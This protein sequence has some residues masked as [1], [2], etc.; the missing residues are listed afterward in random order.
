M[1]ISDIDDGR[2][3]SPASA[4]EAPSAALARLEGYDLRYA[5]S[6]R[7]LDLHAPDGRLCVRL[8]LGEGGPQIEVIGGSLAIRAEEDISLSCRRLDIDAA[9]GMRLR[10]GGEL[11]LSAAGAL[12]SDGFSQHLVARRGDLSLEANDD[13]AVEGERILLNSPQ[14]IVRGT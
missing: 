1:A 4:D 2:E 5:E 13:I 3:A 8:T 7:R 12:R 14:P 9:Q 6:E 10:S 11:E